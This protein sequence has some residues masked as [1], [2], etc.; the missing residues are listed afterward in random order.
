MKLKTILILLLCAVLHNM[1]QAKCITNDKWSGPDK[2]EHAMAGG[3]IS[4]ATTLHT[5][6]PWKGFAW[7]AGIGV[8][9]ELLD[10]GGM[11]TCSLQDLLVTVGAAALGASAGYQLVLVRD[12]QSRTTTVGI[13][14]DGD[15]LK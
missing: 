3:I 8:G 1:V 13:S 5:G 14:I 7:G 4:M 9:K 10:A 15:W 12:R 11:G 2:I 6:D